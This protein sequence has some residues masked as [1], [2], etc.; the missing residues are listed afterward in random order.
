MRGRQE[1]KR[2]DQGEGW[3]L[4]EEHGTFFGAQN[5]PIRSIEPSFPLEAT[6]ARQ[7]LLVRRDE[8][9][10]SVDDKA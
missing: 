6:D 7:L 8:D 3:A 1:L 2:E 10:L 4:Q 5:R 9:W